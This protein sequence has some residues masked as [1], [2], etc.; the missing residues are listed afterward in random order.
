M[1]LTILLELLAR[2]SFLVLDGQPICCPGHLDILFIDVGH[3]G[4]M[5]CNNLLHSEPGSS[6]ARRTREQA[7]T[8]EERT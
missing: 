4:F 5:H 1:R 3:T 7:C 6:H 8:K 2:L